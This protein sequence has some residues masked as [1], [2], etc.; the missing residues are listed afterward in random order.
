MRLTKREQVLLFLLATIGV[1]AAAVVLVINPMNKMIEE[2]RVKLQDLENQKI[3]IE[4]KLLLENKIE[5]D[6]EAA[7]IT[8]H[9]KF[10]RIESPIFS[11]EFERWSLPYLTKNN[12]AMVSFEVGDPFLSVPEVPLYVNAGFQYHVRELVES[13]NQTIAESNTIPTTE[14]ELVRTV[15]RFEFKTSYVVFSNFL[16][17]IAFWDTTV[18]VTNSNYDFAQQA[19]TITVDYY[20]ITK[21]VEQPN[22]VE[23]ETETPVTPAQ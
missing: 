19:G 17:E 23:D 18:F 13:Y 20:T 11:A 15:V 12:V 6:L 16:D 9:E 4:S 5:A 22:T 10:S 3:I 2:N 7:I 8:V 1:V 21:L 14:A